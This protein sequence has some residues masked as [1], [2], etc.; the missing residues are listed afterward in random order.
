MSGRLGFV[1]LSRGK[2]VTG[3]AVRLTEC[4]C[5]G[6]SLCLNSELGGVSREPANARAPSWRRAEGVGSGDGPDFDSASPPPVV[7]VT[8]GKWLLRV[9]FPYL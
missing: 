9:L 2:P 6:F 8:S 4:C 1:P 7:V 3:D 5:S